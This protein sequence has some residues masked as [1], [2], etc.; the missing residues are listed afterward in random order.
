MS[1]F[2][3]DFQYL[4]SWTWPWTSLDIPGHWF[5]KE[6]VT[7]R[8]R[9]LDMIGPAYTVGCGRETRSCPVDTGSWALDMGGF[10]LERFRS[11]QVP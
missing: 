1:G 5:L 8:N 4:G 7:G 10:R 3:L 9:F 2:R 11:K 6:L